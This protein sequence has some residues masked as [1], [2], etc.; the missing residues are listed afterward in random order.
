MHFDWL[1]LSI[2]TIGLLDL[3]HFFSYIPSQYHNALQKAQMQ[4]RLLKN[5]L[6]NLTWNS[7]HS[8]LTLI[9]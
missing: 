4:Y 2:E 7:Q 3:R 1:K 9:S 5:I 8:R 6:K